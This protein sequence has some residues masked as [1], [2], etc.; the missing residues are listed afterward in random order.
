[1]GVRSILRRLSTSI[2][3]VV[4]AFLF[5][6]IPL[7]VVGAVSKEPS[8]SFDYSSLLWRWSFG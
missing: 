1:V 8:C 6:K 4:L 2:I 5:R 7:S 3:I